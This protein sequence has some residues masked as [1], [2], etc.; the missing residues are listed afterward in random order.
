MANST[1][2]DSAPCTDESSLQV[3]EVFKDVPLTRARRR[4]QGRLTPRR[5]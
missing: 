4:R 3:G 2:T 5:R 1:I